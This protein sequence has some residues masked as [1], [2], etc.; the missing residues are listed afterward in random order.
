MQVHAILHFTATVKV[1][2]RKAVY[3]LWELVLEPN[4]RYMVPWRS[5]SIHSYAFSCL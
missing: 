4:T 5:S 2:Q 1:H 3:T